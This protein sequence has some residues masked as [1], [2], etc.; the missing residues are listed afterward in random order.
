MQIYTYSA[1]SHTFSGIHRKMNKI[2]ADHL[3]MILISKHTQDMF[4][5]SLPNFGPLMP[6]LTKKIDKSFEIRTSHSGANMK[7]VEKITAPNF[8][9][10]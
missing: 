4:L 2:S 7:F 3:N 1:G 10:N 9:A 5:F 8:Q 6:I